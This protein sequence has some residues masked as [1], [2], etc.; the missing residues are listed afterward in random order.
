MVRI[1]SRPVLIFWPGTYLEVRHRTRW[2]MPTLHLES[3]SGVFIQW[4]ICPNR[5]NTDYVLAV[6]PEEEWL[7]VVP[8]GG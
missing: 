5:A 8:L 7:E 3:G 1:F 6:Q 4:K 2:S